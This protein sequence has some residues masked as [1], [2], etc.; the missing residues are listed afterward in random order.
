MENLSN[1]LR[2]AFAETVARVIAGVIVGFLI[3]VL[4]GISSY[5]F[6]RFLL[7]EVRVQVLLLVILSL[8]SLVGLLAGVVPIWRIV[9]KKRLLSHIR[10]LDASLEDASKAI[11]DQLAH[12][13]A[14][15]E[16]YVK[17]EQTD[18]KA[19]TLSL[20]DTWETQV[21]QYLQPVDHEQIN[22]LRDEISSRS[23]Q[24]SRKEAKVWISKIKVFTQ[25]TRL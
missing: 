16:I 10:P 8:F 4:A 6:S 2:E 13:E 20:F 23:L 1:W 21:T 24:H 9:T 17:R 12:V 19:K 5:G 11:L 3:A 22:L 15:K 14:G 18:F 7:Q 25:K